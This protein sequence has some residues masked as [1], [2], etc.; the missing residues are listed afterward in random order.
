MKACAGNGLREARAPQRSRGRPRLRA[1]V[2][3]EQSYILRFYPEIEMTGDVLTGH[4]RD[5]LASGSRDPPVSRPVALDSP[6]LENPAARRTTLILSPLPSCF[7]GL[8]RASACS[9]GFRPPFL[10]FSATER[11]L[12]FLL[13]AVHP[14][15]PHTAPYRRSNIAGGCARR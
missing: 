6:P 12:Q 8:A 4:P 11:K 7:F 10:R 14:I 9:V 3:E 13:D 5:S 2:R 15:Q 1:L